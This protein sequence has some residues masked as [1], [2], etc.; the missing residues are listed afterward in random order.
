MVQM[1]QTKR[2]A[3]EA[4]ETYWNQRFLGVERQ[5]R[6]V[7]VFLAVWTEVRCFETLAH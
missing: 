6:G 1:K 5:Q 2:G 4:E 3:V 7:E